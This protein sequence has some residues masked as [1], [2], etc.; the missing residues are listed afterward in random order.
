MRDVW[1]FDDPPETEVILLD[2]ILAGESPILIVTRDE[3]DPAW[4]FLDGDHVFEDDAVI[5]LLGEVAQ[6]DPAVLE[7]RDLPVGWHAW[8]ASPDQGWT[9]GEGEP[10]ATFPTKEGEG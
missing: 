2:R 7:L 9:R 8:R 1:P 3:D 4:Q 6:L 10:P 5:V